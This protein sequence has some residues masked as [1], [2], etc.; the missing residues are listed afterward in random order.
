[1]QLQ[2][3]FNG[4]HGYFGQSKGRIAVKYYS[5][6]VSGLNVL[7]KEGKKETIK[8][9]KMSNNEGELNILSAWLSTKPFLYFSLVSQ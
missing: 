5:V 4:L 1:M 8:E 9:K 6:S 2:R 7:Q 3:D